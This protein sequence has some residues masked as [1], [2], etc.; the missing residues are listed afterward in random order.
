MKTEWISVKDRLPDESMEC[1]VFTD[2]GKQFMA[3]Y[4]RGS[5]DKKHFFAR[6]TKTHGSYSWDDVVTHWIDKLPDPENP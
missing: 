2:F 5:D 3:T 6:D 1:I 4:H